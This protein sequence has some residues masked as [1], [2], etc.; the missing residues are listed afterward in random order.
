MV[1]KAW[2]KLHWRLPILNQIRVD[3]CVII[4]NT[5]SVELHC[6][7]D[8]SERAYGGFVSKRGQDCNGTVQVRLLLSHS[9]VAP[10]RSQLILRL[11]LC[12]AL[13]C[14]QLFEKIRNA[15]ILQ[16]G[17]LVGFNLRVVL[18]ASTTFVANRIARIQNLTDGW[19]WKQ[20][21][22]SRIPRIKHGRHCTHWS[23]VEWSKLVEEWFWIVARYYCWKFWNW[24][25]RKTSYYSCLRG[26]SNCRI[27]RFVPQQ[28]WILYIP[29]SANS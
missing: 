7:L 28:I 27:Q 23:L 19:N 21:R 11:E 13:L 6:F 3:R 26:V 12:G 16:D 17:L 20:S 8:A 15:T 1:G 22:R 2:R 24:R 5:V 18:I 10:L 14:S 25:R 29:H 4:P 9:K